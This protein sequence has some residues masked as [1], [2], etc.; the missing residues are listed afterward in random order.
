MEFMTSDF[1]AELVGTMILVLLGNGVVAGV[2]LRRSKSEN[3]GW[4]VV[5]TGWALG[6][7]MG[8][9]VTGWI[10][11]AHLN[12]AVTVAFVAVG[13]LS[14]GLAFSYISGQVLGAAL[15]SLLVFLAY[16]PH[17]RETDDADAKLSCFCT[18]PAIRRPFFNFLT[19][20]IG[21]AMLLLGVL[22]IADR[23]NGLTGGMAPLAVGL[24]VLGIGLS[25]GGPTGYAINPARDFVPRVMHA[26]LPVPGKRDADWAYS[27]IPIAG[28]LLGGILGA[29]FYKLFVAH[30]NAMGG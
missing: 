17:W 22:G 28:P 1:T 16:Q 6:V 26:L 27:W 21:T 20:V 14:P 24:L 8:I 4:I 25:L 9:Y 5:T 18:M 15:G 12:P 3:A 11:G 13:D 2:L 29:V 19:E 10:S 30:L 7:S 23:H